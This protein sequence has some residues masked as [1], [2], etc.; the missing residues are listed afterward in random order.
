VRVDLSS[1]ALADIANIHAYI[2]SDSPRG[3]RR[4][5]QRVRQTLSL[6][7]N[8]PFIGRPGADPDTRE[9]PVWSL[10]YVIVY[11]VRE[12]QNAV[13]ILRIFHGSQ[14]RNP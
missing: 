1:P 5:V 4:V 8:H 3:A 7:A 14:G 11:E 12:D 13:M 9:I 2:A 6:L 10:P